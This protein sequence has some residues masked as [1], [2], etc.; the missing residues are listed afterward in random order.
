MYYRFSIFFLVRGIYSLTPLTSSLTTTLTM[1]VRKFTSLIISVF[2]FSNPFTPMHWVG[3]A[4][5]FLGTVGY[6][7]ASQ[8]PPAVAKGGAKHKQRSSAAS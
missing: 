4:T 6:V 2:Y 3:S 5:V 7:L 1:T 8:H